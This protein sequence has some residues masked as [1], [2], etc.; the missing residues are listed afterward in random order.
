MANLINGIALRVEALENTD[1]SF[2]VLSQSPNNQGY[3]VR[4]YN[5]NTHSYDNFDH[6]DNFGPA[7]Y[8]FKVRSIEENGNNYRSIYGETRGNRS[9]ALALFAENMCGDSG[10]ELE[11]F[12]KL[13]KGSYR[14][15]QTFI[16]KTLQASFESSDLPSLNVQ[17]T[18][19]N[20]A[21]IE[22]R[23][24]DPITG[25]YTSI[26]VYKNYQNGFHVFAV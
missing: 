7:W 10:L 15:A 8:G 21:L 3:L 24:F 6:Y 9:E 17:L 14:D 26:A 4:D 22:S 18:D 20:L 5:A 25:I 2:L 19:L 12:D 1:N 16:Y 11:D 23:W 13:Y